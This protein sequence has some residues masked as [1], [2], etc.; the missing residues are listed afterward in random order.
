MM[1]KNDVIEQ[2]IEAYSLVGYDNAYQFIVLDEYG[3][4][5]EMEG[6]SGSKGVPYLRTLEA[7]GKRGRVIEYSYE[8]M[9]ILVMGGRRL[10][11]AESKG[12]FRL[13][14]TV[15]KNNMVYIKRDVKGQIL[16][17]DSDYIYFD[18]GT[19][20][21]IGGADAIKAKYRMDFK[22][23]KIEAMTP[24]EFNRAWEDYKKESD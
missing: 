1:D 20:Y 18:K 11:G 13:P 5:Y 10:R 9:G 24:Q 3:V 4:E 16:F 6:Y 22:G 21:F 17:E 8:S 19:K 7:L 12:V 23:V 15:A 2:I 14:K